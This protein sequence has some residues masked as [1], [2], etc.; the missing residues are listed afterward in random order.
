M[1]VR[2]AVIL[3]GGKGTRLRPYTTSIPKPLVP[4]GDESA[5]LEIVLRQLARDGFKRVTIAIG[6]LG[7]LI[8]AYVGSGEQW[9]LEVDYATEAKPLSTMGPV[10]AILDKLPEQFLVLNG[11]ILTDL[12]FSALLDA[13]S[14]SNA[15]LTIATYHRHVDV[16]FGVLTVE[17]G[18]VVGFVEKPTLNYQVSMGVYAV[19]R[20]AL[21]GYPAGEALGF[22]R[23]VIDLLAAGRNPASYA[24]EGYWLDIGRPEDYDRAN[25][26]FVR[27]RSHLLPGS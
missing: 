24:F 6:H 26:E 20:A 23:L 17:A 3:A 18:R 25:S 5:I 22:D 27:L 8:R 1:S 13:H 15:Q 11:D 19:S 9:G 2:H 14:A 21:A 4:I 12:S 7:E 10:V 16:D